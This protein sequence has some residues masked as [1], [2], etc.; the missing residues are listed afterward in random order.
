LLIKRSPA[1]LELFELEPVI[2][3]AERLI[4]DTEDKTVAYKSGVPDNAYG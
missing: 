1:N 3:F 4:G 2:S